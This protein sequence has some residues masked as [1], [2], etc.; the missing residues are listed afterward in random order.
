[1]LG[2]QRLL[3]LLDN[4]E[5]VVEAAP[6]VADLVATCSKLAVL[7][8]SRTRL[9]LSGEREVPV[10]PLAVPAAGA[11]E[12]LAGFA[13]VRLFVERAQGI[14]P[15]FALS[16]TNAGKVAT[17]CRRL[18]GLPLAIE[19]AAARVAHLPPDA[20]LVRLEAGL[21]LLSGGPRDAPTRLRTMR[22]AIAWS[23][24]LL[25]P[26]DQ[27]LFRRMA[28]FVGGFTLE[29]AAAVGE[30]MGEPHGDPFDGI[31]S[32]LDASL[33]R[34]EA[35]PGGEPRY[36]MLETVRGYG[37]EQLAASGD[38]AAAR[39]AHAAFFLALAERAAPDWFRN[40][41]PASL[42]RLAADHDNLRAT[43]EHLCRAETAEAC[44]RLV[45]VCGWYWFARG[46]IREG[47]ALVERALALPTPGPSAA[48]SGALHRAG[49]LAMAMGDLATVAERVREG[50]RVWEAVGDPRGR[51]A[52]L[53][54]LGLVEER[55]S[56]WDAATALFQQELAIWRELGDRHRIGLDLRLLGLVAYGQGQ[57]ARARALVEEA[58]ALFR[59]ID[60]RLWV[61]A[62]DWD[63]GLFATAEGRFPEA[64]RHCR[65]SLLGYAEAGDQS[66]LHQ[67]LIGLA[68]MAVEAGRPEAAG[69][70]LGAVDARLQRTGAVLTLLDRPAYERAEAGAR[71]ALGAA[72]FAAAHAAGRDLDQDA[73]LAE[74]DRI[75]AAVEAARRDGGA[76]PAPHGLTPRERE[77]VQLLAAGR[78]NREIADALFV[79][80][81]TAVTHVRHI[82]AK[83]G[84]DSRTAVAA[85]A[86][87]HGLA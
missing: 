87:R 9:R 66:Y 64:A 77:V 79:G 13:A 3:L 72:G 54:M 62:T 52:A 27:A 80:H 2:D 5:Q 70:L 71:A 81:S 58:A 30:A 61:A 68:A 60:N 34:Q 24:D 28:V 85:W 8:T 53:H 7:V 39:A 49:V 15:D 26:G 56:H 21:G 44:L 23:Y 38:D 55:Q 76:S 82:L 57:L 73:L 51:A 18:D 67:P 14:R 20:L 86:V 25:S 33:L 69:Q 47:R 45:G 63:L 10:P 78:T 19:L 48:R 42:D 36:Q 29:A 4:F 43:F 35:G 40:T 84:L 59:Q 74:A 11:V 50:L 65:A 37:L 17:I 31:A 22:D 16:E 6:L 1:M 46:H 12:E 75:V 32:L 83:L 41:A